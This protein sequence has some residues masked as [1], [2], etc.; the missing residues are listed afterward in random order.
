MIPKRKSSKLTLLFVGALLLLS[1]LLGKDAPH[2][3]G[4]HVA[5]APEELFSI[6]GFPVT[7]TLFWGIFLA[8]V[9]IALALRLRSTL[10][11]VPRGFQN[12]AE[13]LIEKF[14]DFTTTITG[15]VEKTKKIFPLAFS[16]FLFILFA[17]LFAFLPASAVTFHGE[18]LFRAVITDYNLVLFM[19]LTVVIIIQIVAVAASGPFGYLKKFINFSSP[20]NFVLGLMD[21]IGELS[22]VLSMSFRLFGN[23][24]AGEVLVAVMLSLMPYFVPLPFMLTGL[25]A[26]VIQAFV[27][28]LLTIVFITMASEKASHGA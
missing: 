17:N 12:V 9:L 15:S 26:A 14:F 11:E 7:N 24:F 1:F 5:I 10:E 6:G 23:I 13:A 18:P 2:E 25:L 19:T 27:F 3:S 8:L 16:L 4:V 28:S 21:I 22:K 20:L